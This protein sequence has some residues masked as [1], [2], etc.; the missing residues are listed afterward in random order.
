MSLARRASIS[1]PRVF[2]RAPVAAD[3]DEFIDLV[4]RSHR[5]LRPFA[6]PPDNALGF[7][8]Y[9]DRCAQD[10]YAGRFLC[11]MADR[12]IMGVFNVSQIVRMN[13]KCAFLGYWVGKQFAGQGYMTEGLRLLL[14]EAFTT[15]GLH[16]LE[17]N[18]Q[19]DN[20]RSKALAERCGFV[21]E[22]FSERYLKIG[23]RWRDHERWAITKEIWRAG[24]GQ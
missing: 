20:V 11:R 16:R 3:R 8:K 14:R 2:L 7:A 19:P 18:I 4:V 13:F 15:L 22:G 1:Q 17:A 6:A 21:K 10:N 9:L 24:R 23:G 12:R 5:F